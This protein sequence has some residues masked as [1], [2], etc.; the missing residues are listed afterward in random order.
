[1]TDTYVSTTGLIHLRAQIQIVTHT[2][3]RACSD[4]HQTTTAISLNV[5]VLQVLYRYVSYKSTELMNV[6]KS[7]AAMADTAD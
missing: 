5:Q 4:A 6:T 2:N 1:M 7:T 3:Y